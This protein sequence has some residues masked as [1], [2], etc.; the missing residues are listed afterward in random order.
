MAIG[1]LLTIPSGYIALVPGYTLPWVEAARTILVVFLMAW[2][3]GA[4]RIS[5]SGTPASSVAIGL[6]PGLPV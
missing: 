4:I 3:V 6:G 5:K 1:L 2:S